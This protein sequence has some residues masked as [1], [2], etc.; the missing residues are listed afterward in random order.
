MNSPAMFVQTKMAPCRRMHANAAPTNALTTNT[1]TT[2]IALIGRDA[3]TIMIAAV[4]NPTALTMF[5]SASEMNAQT[6]MAPQSKTHVCAAAMN[7][8]IT[9][10]A[11]TEIAIEATPTFQW[12]TSNAQLLS[13]NSTYYRGPKMWTRIISKVT[14]SLMSVT[15]VVVI[16]PSLTIMPAPRI[17]L[18]PLDAQNIIYS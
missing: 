1:A 18:I 14:V 13:I 2:E 5:V 16:A 6:R 3:Q 11:T 7:A 4:I 10:T 8:L 15:F 12:F 9:S 17:L